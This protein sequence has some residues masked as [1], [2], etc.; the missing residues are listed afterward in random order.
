VC[1]RNAW[2]GQN[3]RDRGADP[4]P[5]AGK[6]ATPERAVL[7]HD[8]DSILLR[9]GTSSGRGRRPAADMSGDDST[10]VG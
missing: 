5:N 7:E 9:G 3:C 2:Q 1:L 4:D 8:D 10:T 6:N